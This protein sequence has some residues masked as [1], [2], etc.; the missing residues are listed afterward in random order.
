MFYEIRHK[1]LVIL[2]PISFLLFQKDLQT[3]LSSKVYLSLALCTFSDFNIIKLITIT[4]LDEGYRSEN[5]AK[6]GIYSEDYT[7]AMYYV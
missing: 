7:R 5:S 4:I 6:S 1:L 3:N 2:S